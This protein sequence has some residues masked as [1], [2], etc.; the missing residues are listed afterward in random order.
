[1][2]LP[3]A[4]ARFIDWVERFFGAVMKIVDPVF[5]FVSTLPGW[6]W[7]AVL[8]AP[9]ALFGFVYLRWWFGRRA[10][11]EQY[12][13]LS[14][15]TLLDDNAS[16]TALFPHLSVF[17]DPA[18]SDVETLWGCEGSSGGRE[19]WLADF[20]RRSGKQTLMRTAAV[21][22]VP[23]ADWPELSLWERKGGVPRGSGSVDPSDADFDRT[24]QAEGPRLDAA[25]KSLTAEARAGLVRLAS[26]VP[27]DR[28]T[29][30]HTRSASGAEGSPSERAP[31]RGACGGSH[32]HLRAPMHR[33]R[34]RQ[35][36]PGRRRRGLFDPGPVRRQKDR[37]GELNRLR[38][39]PDG[40]GRDSRSGGTTGARCH[41]RDTYG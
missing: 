8:L 23:G 6:L 13:K 12:A 14:G 32:C 18:N 28:A 34:R 20:N 5:E 25:L 24:F 40:R 27:G 36:P 41:G 22:R 9:A 10:R 4:L 21:L 1:M 37:E 7:I 17:A 39:G 16:L 11:W 38:Q 15:F 19:V 31:S 33:P 26:P 30:R 3:D 29:S 35:G 2:R